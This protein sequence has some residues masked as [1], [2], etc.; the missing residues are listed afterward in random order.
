M[1]NLTKVIAK[2]ITC[3]GLGLLGAY[4]FA[5]C[6]DCLC[7]TNVLAFASVTY[8]GALTLR[9]ICLHQQKK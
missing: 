4:S 5:V 9:Y 6:Q 8:P 3:L 7:L 1:R 2:H